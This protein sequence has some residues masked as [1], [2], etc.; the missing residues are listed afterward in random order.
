MGAVKHWL[1]DEA[2]KF[3]D[4]IESKVKNKKI[5]KGCALMLCLAEERIA[6]ELVGFDVS[7]NSELKIELNQWIQGIKV[8]EPWGKKIK[9]VRF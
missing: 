8:E 3:M 6:W 1:Q 4:E 5:T 7:S 2:E 9:D